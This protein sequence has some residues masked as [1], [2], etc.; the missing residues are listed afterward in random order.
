MI[1]SPK[2]VAIRLSVSPAL[3]LY[4]RNAEPSIG[5]PTR[6]WA[7]AGPAELACGLGDGLS[8]GE[9]EGLGLALRAATRVAS[10]A[11]VPDCVSGSEAIAAVATSIRQTATAITPFRPTRPDRVRANRGFWP[12]SPAV[13][14]MVA[15]AIGAVSPV[16]RARRV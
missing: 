11:A 8:D 6:G 13:R 10:F 4:A 1:D 12:E 9:A 5:V 2:A 3:T 15:S 7:V 14:S 16:S